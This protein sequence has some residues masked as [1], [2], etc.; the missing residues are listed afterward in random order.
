M[1]MATDDAGVFLEVATTIGSDTV[2]AVE[3]LHSSDSDDEPLLSNTQYF[4][5]AVAVNLMDICVS[6]PISLQL[7][8]TTEAWTTA[9]SVPGA[10]PS[11]YFLRATG[12][13]ISMLILR[14]ANMQ[15]A[16][17]TGFKIKIGDTTG[18]HIDSSIDADDDVTFNAT[19]LQANS[20][21]KVSVAV[22]TNLGISSFSSPSIMSTTTSTAPST[23]RDV[24][25]A[26]VTGNSAL[27][28]W[29][30]LST[31]CCQQ[32]IRSF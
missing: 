12:G 9:A 5:K 11:P 21:Y 3:I 13:M 30:S 26:N 17:C 18:H 20:S 23:P 7:T 27:L 6:V 14:P 22:I 32:V 29:S 15:G 28:E 2:D 16:N 8:N 25:V 24:S 19:S 31:S 1:Y 4:F 10:P